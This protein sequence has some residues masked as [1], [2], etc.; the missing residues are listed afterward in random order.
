MFWIVAYKVWLMIIRVSR[1]PIGVNVV[2][3]KVVM[4]TG[5]RVTN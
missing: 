3:A 5:D 2:K 1:T 4:A